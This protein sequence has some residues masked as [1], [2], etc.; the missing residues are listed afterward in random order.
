MTQ[1]EFD[2]LNRALAEAN[3]ALK[4]LLI[5]FPDST[6][7]PEWLARNDEAREAL[8]TARVR[9]AVE[10]NMARWPCTYCGGDR[11]NTGWHC[12]SCGAC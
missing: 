3:T 8:I 5:S 9:S 12:S 4:S 10:E 7:Y 2:I 6:N 1:A 11:T